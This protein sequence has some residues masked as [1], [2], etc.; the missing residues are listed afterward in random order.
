MNIVIKGFMADGLGVMHYK[1]VQYGHFFPT[2]KKKYQTGLFKPDQAS[3]T[4]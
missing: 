3:K 1:I 4:L 2:K